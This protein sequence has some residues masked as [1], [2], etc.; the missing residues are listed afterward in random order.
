MIY[1]LR[2]EVHYLEADG[3]AVTGMRTRSIEP[4]K[5]IDLQL[6]ES[7]EAMATE[8]A[9]AVLQEGWMVSSANLKGGIAFWVKSIPP[10]RILTV[11]VTVHGK[12]GA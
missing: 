4:E 7:I 2:T 12:E 9:D 8:E 1:E 3:E 11:F 5:D 10:H 6:E